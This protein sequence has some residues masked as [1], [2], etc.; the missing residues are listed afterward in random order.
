MIGVEIPVFGCWTFTGHYKDH[1]VTFTLWVTSY[2]EE[3][4]SVHAQVL[5]LRLPPPKR[6]NIPR[7]HIDAETQAKE[8]VYRTLP[9]LPSSPETA[10][11]SGTIVLHAI[12]GINGKAREL[13]YISGPKPLLQPAIDSVKWWR[14]RICS[15]SKDPEIPNEVDTTIAVEFPPR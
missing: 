5:A 11:A 12:I 14:Y 2:T 13:T 8:L 4:R 7:V 9:E 10:D 15:V 1:D 6:S 3:E